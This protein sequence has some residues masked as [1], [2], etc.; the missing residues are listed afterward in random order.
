[1]EA[2]M[3]HEPLDTAA[4][5]EHGER[6]HATKRIGRFDGESIAWRTFAETSERARRLATALS[7][8]GVT[9]NTRVAT[10]CWNDFAHFEAYLAVPAM[11]AVL[12]TLNLRLH[13]DQIGFIMSDAED[14][15][16]IADAQLLAGVLSQ[17]NALES[18]APDSSIRL[19]A[20]T[21]VPNAPPEELISRPEI[22]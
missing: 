1:M 19:T 10:L 7:E 17:V 16:M 18:L 15:V 3:M 20:V 11:G 2:T 22:P 4:I 5:F 9:A 13:P 21:P 8:A 14:T 12:H 6:I